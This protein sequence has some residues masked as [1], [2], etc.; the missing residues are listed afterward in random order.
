MASRLEDY[1]ASTAP[2]A[3][4]VEAVP[5][6]LPGQIAATLRDRIQV[7]EFKP[8]DP[9]RAAP[10]A[11]AFGCSRGPVREALKRLERE[12][13]VKIAP[14]TGAVVAS[15][16]P[17][18]LAAHFRLRAE[19]G[20]LFVRLAAE[21]VQRPPALVAAILE[22]AE[23]LA[24]VAADEQAKVADYIH[25]RRRLTDLIAT[26]AAAPYVSEL[27]LE[28]ER[29]VAILWAPL[30]S[31]ARRRRSASGWRKIARAIATGDPQSAETEGRRMVLEALEETQ[32]L[33][34]GG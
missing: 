11:V 32:R 2:L 24:D 5:E 14:R 21:R 19:V 31:A 7:G 16:D 10:L 23:V 29:E 15:M 8:G 1:L 20:A 33:S 13:L 3:A 26:L 28:L 18:A 6:G 12:K 22:G 34:S 9:L 27:S 4:Q 17:T 30:L 25:A